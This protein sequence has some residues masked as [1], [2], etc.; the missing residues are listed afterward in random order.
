MMDVGHL[1][2]SALQ[3]PY[4]PHNASWMSMYDLDRILV[5]PSTVATL[6]PSELEELSGYEDYFAGDGTDPSPVSTTPPPVKHQ[7]LRYFHKRY[8]PSVVHLSEIAT[9]DYV[10]GNGDR[11]PNKNNF[12]VGGCKHRCS[13]SLESYYPHRKDKHGKKKKGKGRSLKHTGVPNYVHLDQGMGWYPTMEVRNNPI[14]KAYHSYHKLQQQQEGD[15]NKKVEEFHF[16]LFRAPLLNRIRQL[17]KDH[18]VKAGRSWFHHLMRE[19]SEGTAMQGEAAVVPSNP[20]GDDD[21]EQESDHDMEEETLAI[22]QLHALEPLL[23]VP[24]DI[25]KFLSG[26]VLQQCSKRMLH[27][28]LVA[29]RCLEVGALSSPDAASWVITP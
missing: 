16:C 26:S 20:A 1:L 11:S 15:K 23:P 17:V 21:T 5:D 22:Q 27:I 8:L 28:L 25:Q 10:I 19:T 24:S 7:L 3:I 12:V 29:D 18:P 9:F 6:P 14:G 13:N 2:D 4:I